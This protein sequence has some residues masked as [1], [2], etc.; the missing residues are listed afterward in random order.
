MSKIEES[1]EV[2]V[3]LRTVYDQ[4]TQFEDFPRFMEGVEHIEQRTPT[5][6]HWVTEFGGVRREFDAEITE[7]SPDERI[8]WTTV[9]GE[10]RQAGV[11]TFHRL[12]DTH[13]KV[14]LQLDHD[15]AGIADTVGDKLGLVRRQAKGD[16]GR[17]KSFIEERGV[18][19]GAWRGTA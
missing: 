7:Q 5:L 17:F 1:V 14:M 16:L 3:P 19:S 11:V 8:A 6:T 10:V 4:W 2:A 18:A 9:R 15:P 13:T 12:D